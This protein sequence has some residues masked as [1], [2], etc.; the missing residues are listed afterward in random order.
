MVVLFDILLDYQVKMCEKLFA[1]YQLLLGTTNHKLFIN[2]YQKRP[3]LTQ[4]KKVIDF[5]NIRLLSVAILVNQLFVV[6][7]NSA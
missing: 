3:F 2:Q 7:Y 1:I 5:T 4:I 6:F